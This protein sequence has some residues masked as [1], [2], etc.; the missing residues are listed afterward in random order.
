MFDDNRTMSASTLCD[1][2]ASLIEV[3]EVISSNCEL[4]LGGPVC[5]VE[6]DETFLNK[7]K[8]H[9]GRIIETHSL[10]VFGIMCRENKQGIIFHVPSK[11]KR[12][13]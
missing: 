3:R 9:R 2:Y 12:D 8:Y 11:A 6:A 1:M 10:T 5:T 13:I 7:R 4:L